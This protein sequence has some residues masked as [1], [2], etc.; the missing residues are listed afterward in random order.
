M[1]YRCGGLNV[2]LFAFLTR[3]ASCN[4]PEMSMSNDALQKNKE[5]THRLSSGTGRSNFTLAANSL[6]ISYCCRR[7]EIRA[8]R[9][10]FCPRTLIVL[11]FRHILANVWNSPHRMK[12]SIASG[13]NET[14]FRQLV[15]K[16]NAI[17]LLKGAS[18][19]IKWNDSY[20]IG[21]PP[22]VR[23]TTACRIILTVVPMP[24][25]TSL[26]AQPTMSVATWE[27][28]VDP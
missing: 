26:L 9:S 6:G 24:S 27:D 18:M 21:K 4:F 7:A 22:G 8:L 28:G 23:E 14:S 20:G 10:T 25:S 19:S 1:R 17:I 16:R 3:G 13:Q 15:E 2:L 12:S 5:A 11:M